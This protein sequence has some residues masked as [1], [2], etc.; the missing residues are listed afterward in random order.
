MSWDLSRRSDE[1][2]VDP[3]VSRSSSQ[4]DRTREALRNLEDTPDFCAFVDEAKGSNLEN[5]D[6]IPSLDK[7]AFDWDRV[8]W[9]ESFE[10]AATN[11][12][13]GRAAK[14]YEDLIAGN[15]KPRFSTGFLLRNGFPN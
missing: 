14:V 2:Y 12:K 3:I 5:V 9:V 15:I 7:E 4:E 10:T 1:Q 8:K 6:G 11:D 13:T